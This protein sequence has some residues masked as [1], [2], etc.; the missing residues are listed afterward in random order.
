VSA[1]RH[2]SLW[3]EEP[4]GPDG[5]TIGQ[6]VGVNTLG[7]LYVI[8]AHGRTRV[9]HA[10]GGVD[11]GIRVEAPGVDWLPAKPEAGRPR[12]LTSTHAHNTRMAGRAPEG[13][14]TLTVG[15]LPDWVRSGDHVRVG[16]DT[17]ATHGTTVAP[18]SSGSVLNIAAALP[19]SATKGQVVAVGRWAAGPSLS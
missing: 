19:S 17:G 10:I 8:D 9:K 7:D 16:L 5:V 14:S 2:P 3:T 18:G 1:D 12:H 13:A 15:S 11:I 4:H 6:G